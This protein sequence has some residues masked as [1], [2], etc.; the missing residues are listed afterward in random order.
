MFKEDDRLDDVGKKPLNSAKDLLFFSL[1]H[2]IL[3][4]TRKIT[5]MFEVLLFFAFMAAS[6][7]LGYRYTLDF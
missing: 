6:F 1:I 5:K 4:I 3:I 2:L 7:Y